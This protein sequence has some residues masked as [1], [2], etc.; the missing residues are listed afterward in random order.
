MAS[1]EAS[2]RLD[3]LRRVLRGRKKKNKIDKIF[4][5]LYNQKGNRANLRDD[6]LEMWKT[7]HP[8]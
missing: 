1:A 7:V 3:Y 2:L 6:I 4:K 5:D 8:E